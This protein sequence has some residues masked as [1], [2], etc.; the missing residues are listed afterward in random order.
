MFVL[1]RLPGK[2]DSITCVAYSPDGRWLAAH[3][4]PEADIVA[5]RRGEV[6]LWDLVARGERA[7]LRGSRNFGRSVAFSPDGRLLAAGLGDRSVR[8]WDVAT[9]EERSV[10]REHSRAAGALAFSPDGKTLVTG[11]GDR[12]GTGRSG[13]VNVWDVTRAQSLGSLDEPDGVWA[14]AY[15]PDGQAVILGTA[16]VSRWPNPPYGGVKPLLTPRTVARALAL[17]PDGTTLAVTAGWSVKLYTLPQVRQRATLTGHK[18][19]VTSLAFSHDGATLASGSADGTVRFWDT[20]SGRPRACFAWGMGNVQSVAFAPD[21]LTAAAGGKSPNN[22]V[23][24]DI[25]GAAG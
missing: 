25:D 5:T 4:A 21:G 15:E 12:S 2:E 6:K 19:I 11:A 14:A 20:A 23:I 16:A 8:L 3:V 22:L 18:Q 13:E 7:V 17:A 24:W 9:L 1:D 10:L